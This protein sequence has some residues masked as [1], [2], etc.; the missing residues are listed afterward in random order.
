MLCCTLFAKIA[1]LF[2]ECRKVA[3]LD[4]L[5][6]WRYLP[7]TWLFEAAGNVVSDAFDTVLSAGQAWQMMTADPATSQPEGFVYPDGYLLFA[8]RHGGTWQRPAAALFICRRLIV[9]EGSAVMAL[10]RD[11]GGWHA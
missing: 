3:K 11:E 9:P 4:W 8:G 1:V 2:A 10:Y 7:G 5:S 6:W